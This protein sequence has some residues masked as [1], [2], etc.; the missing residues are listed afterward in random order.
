MFPVFLALVIFNPG[1]EVMPQIVGLYKTVDECFVKARDQNHKLERVNTLVA[2]DR[3]YVCL[4][5]RG[6]V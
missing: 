6:D 3:G 1:G 4:T 2:P 5:I